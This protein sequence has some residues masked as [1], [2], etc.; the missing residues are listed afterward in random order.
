M[1]TKLARAVKSIC[2]VDN[3]HILLWDFDNISFK[4]VVKSLEHIQN[5]YALSHIYIISSRNGFN[6]FCLDK[7][8]LEFAYEIKCNTKYDDYFHQINGFDLGGWCL[9]IDKDK[10]FKTM[11]PSLTYN[12]GSYAHKEFFQL[13]FYIECE[14][15][16]DDNR[17]LAINY[18]RCKNAKNK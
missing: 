18:Y 8:S 5:I 7:M 13:M 16:F 17:L 2:P 11:L 15:F 4:K 1:N 14:G 10:K 6:A 3:K 9:R 12:M